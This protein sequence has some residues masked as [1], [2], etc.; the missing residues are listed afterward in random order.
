MTKIKVDFITFC[1]PGDMDR[2]HRSGVLKTIVQTHNYFFDNV[3]VVH[4]NCRG[5]TYTPFD[6]P[7]RIVESESHPNIL[8]EYG[9]PEHDEKADH[10]THGPTAPHYWKK[11]VI[12]HLIG[13]KVSDADFI[14]F[15]DSD[16]YIRN[17]DPNLPWIV[18][19]IDILKTWQRDVLTVCP[20]DGGMMAEKMIP[21]AR[22]TQN[23][24]QQM[25]L[26]ERERFNQIDFAIPWDWEFL[27]P[28]GPFQEYY[29]M[30][31]GRIWRY[32]HKH[33][34]YRAILPRTWR[35]WHGLDSEFWR[36]L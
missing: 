32:M 10:Y 20:S 19:G 24:S 7:V 33:N 35:Y 27:A 2:L 16:C 21:P 17:Q 15:T 11:H 9:L 30:L 25:F 12:N 4:Q 5:L 23:N 14:M 26:I 13:A 28:A 31:E 29:Y 18:Q 36:L 22:L 1:H 8:T 34:L 3:I 6:F